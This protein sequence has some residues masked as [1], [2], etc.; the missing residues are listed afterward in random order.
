MD[1]KEKKVEITNPTHDSNTFTAKV[2]KGRHHRGGFFKIWMFL[3][4]V[5]MLLQNTVWPEVS[6]QPEGF[7][8]VSTL[9]ISVLDEI[10]K[11]VYPYM[12]TAIEWI[13]NKAPVVINF[14]TKEVWPF[15]VCFASATFHLWWK[16]CLI[17]LGIMA[18]VFVVFFIVCFVMRF[19]DKK[20]AD[21]LM[22]EAKTA[23]SE[24]W[25]EFKKEWNELFGN[26]KKNNDFPK[27]EQEHSEEG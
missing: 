14:I 17:V 6:T 24:S 1:K 18:F 16:S 23:F 10:C 8:K 3:G 12:S 21:Q 25:Q 13:V 2:F 26:S 22:K 20:K 4:L 5:M 15:I 27:P 11:F 19:T 9:W 7:Y